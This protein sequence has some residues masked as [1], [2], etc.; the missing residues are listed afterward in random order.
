MGDPV[1]R[2]QWSRFARFPIE[3]LTVQPQTGDVIGAD[4]LAG[5]LVA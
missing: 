2:V 1:E 4:P 3:V 5:L